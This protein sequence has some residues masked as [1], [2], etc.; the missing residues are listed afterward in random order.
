MVSDRTQIICVC[1]CQ[2]MK[3]VIF[4]DSKEAFM[5]RFYSFILALLGSAVY[6]STDETYIQVIS[7]IIA[8][9]I[10]LCLVLNCVVNCIFWHRKETTDN[11]PSTYYTMKG[12]NV[13]P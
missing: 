7:V 1:C 13:Y 3:T 11:S 10:P 6:T 12:Y 4:G 5:L 9:L 8:C 2:I